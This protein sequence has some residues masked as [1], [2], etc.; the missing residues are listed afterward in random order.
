[1]QRIGI[2]NNIQ[3]LV[4]DA[5]PQDFRGKYNIDGIAILKNLDANNIKTSSEKT[6]AKISE[7]EEKIWYK[8]KSKFP[9]ILII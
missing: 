6:T 2:S 3:R 9:Y 4:L 7:A 5:I 1:M 8:E